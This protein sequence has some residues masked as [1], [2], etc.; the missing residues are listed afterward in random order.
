MDIVARFNAAH[1]PGAC[2]CACLCA[3]WVYGSDDTPRSSCTYRSLLYASPSSLSIHVLNTTG[4]VRWLSIGAA[5]AK[6]KD[7]KAH[8]SAHHSA[9]SGGKMSQSTKESPNVFGFVNRMEVHQSARPAAGIISASS[10]TQRVA[11]VPKK[12]THVSKLF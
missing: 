8:K 12:P 3:W 6:A 4:T 9:S 5:K 2:I 1:Q 11:V 7:R 10:G